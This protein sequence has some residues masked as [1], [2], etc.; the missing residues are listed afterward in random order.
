MIDKELSKLKDDIPN[1]NIGDFKDGVIERYNKKT[2]KKI[3]FK[4]KSIFIPTSL[5]IIVF[6]MILLIPKNLKP[7][8]EGNINFIKYPNII[9]PTYEGFIKESFESN[10]GEIDKEDE[11][12]PLPS[13]S[14]IDGYFNE[15]QYDNSQQQPS[16]GGNNVD[17]S[18]I[19]N[20]QTFEYIYEVEYKNN[21]SSLEYITVYLEKKLANL[22]YEDNKNVTDV[23]NVSPLNIVNGSIVKWFYSKTYYDKTK[24]L[25]CQYD[26]A[27]QIYSEIEDF[28]CVGVYYPQQRIIVREIFSNNKINI[29]DDVYSELYFINDGDKYLKPVVAKAKDEIKWFTSNYI[30]DENNKIELFYCFLK[31]DCEINIEADTI[32]L[33][34]YA[35]QGEELEK[36]N[37]IT[38]LKEY[39][40]LSNS[41]IIENEHPN[42]KF[43]QTS[44][45]IY[46]YSKLIEILQTLNKNNE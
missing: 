11:A 8:I 7:N 29:I 41:I 39:H 33:K 9:N 34:T 15:I 14:V 40:I 2:S 28:I 5:I 44:D 6:L 43:G 22:I 35:V 23:Q 13:P 30:I 21:E 1:I 26:S 24:V 25:W 45:I 17:Y 18:N 42:K 12:G 10:M 19:P 31:M 46:R 27:D 3:V 32:K 36:N 16:V 4:Y 37:Y 38:A 20:L